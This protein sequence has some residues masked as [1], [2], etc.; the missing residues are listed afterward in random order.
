MKVLKCHRNY[1]QHTYYLLTKRENLIN[2]NIVK[3]ANGKY[4]FSKNHLFSSPSQ[5]AAVVLERNA[6]GWIEWKNIVGAT[7]IP[8]KGRMLSEAEFSA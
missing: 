1:K 6:N 3:N 4:T 7:L 8:L 2:E 5:A